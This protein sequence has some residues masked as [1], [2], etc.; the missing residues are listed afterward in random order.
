MARTRESEAMSWLARL[1]LAVPHHVVVASPSEVDVARFSGPPY[2]AKPDV[3]LGG[4]GAR[5]LVA[6]CA[7]HD[8]LRAEVRALL[9][10]DIEGVAVDAVV[11]E[12]AIEGEELYL[13]VAIDEARGPVVRLASSGGI[14]F[15]AAAAAVIAP[16]TF[17]P[18][19]D[20]ELTTLVDAAGI[21]DGVLAG[22][23]KHITDVIWRAFVASEATLLELNP[24]RWDGRR[25]VAVGAALEFDDDARSAARA[26]WPRV[27]QHPAA[28]LGRP[29]TPREA[30]VAVAAVPGR[31]S[32]SFIELGGDVA[33]LVVGGGAGLVCFDR[34]RRLGLRPA[35]IADHSPG[36]GEVALRS[37]IEAGL[38]IPGVR[39]A[40]FGAVVISLADTVPYARAFVD[41][42]R[43]ASVAVEGLPIVVRLAGPNEDEAHRILATYPGLVVLGRESTIEDACDVLAARMGQGG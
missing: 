25:A 9:A 34:L 19:L 38:S 33:M 2:I 20:R 10:A 39:G 8:E 28:R 40:I 21:T 12:E 32:S 30:Q 37:I 7:D 36:A 31:P 26:F 16:A 14:G 6:A 41:G 15:D 1:G 18:L 24:I 43:H 23:L 42:A 3:A 22:H 13:S 5:G 4:K 27:D 29:P 11:V 35:C 17:E